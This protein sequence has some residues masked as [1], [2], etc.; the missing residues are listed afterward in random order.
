MF[1]LESKSPHVINL[2]L[3]KFPEI[4]SK[5]TSL[6]LYDHFYEKTS[7]NLLVPITSARRIIVWG[8]NILSGG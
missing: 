4:V 2:P 6:C 3:L 7:T 1:L 5:H 8:M